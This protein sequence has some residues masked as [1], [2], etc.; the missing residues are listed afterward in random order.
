MLLTHILMIVKTLL[1]SK[2]QIFNLNNHKMLTLGKIFTMISKFVNKKLVNHKSKV[3][4]SPKVIKISNNKILK[5]TKYKISV[6]IKEG[7]SKTIS[8]YRFLDLLYKK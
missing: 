3:V 4:G 2:N 8:W 7:L 6:D 1:N 5:K